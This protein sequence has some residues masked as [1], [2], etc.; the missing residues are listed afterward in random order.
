MTKFIEIDDSQKEFFWNNINSNRRESWEKLAEGLGISRPTMFNYKLGKTKIQQDIFLKLCKIGRIDSS[1]IKFNVTFKS[2]EIKK[3]ELDGI[4]AEF[5]GIIYG[6]GHLGNIKYEV[7]ITGNAITDK[8]YMESHVAPLF[9]DLF[10]LKPDIREQKEF[11]AIRCRVYSKELQMFLKSN[12]NTPSG[13]KTEKL[14]IPNKIKSN[15]KLLVSFIRGLF[16][17]DGSIYT[18]HGNDMMLEISVKGKVFRND[19]F[20]ALKYLGFSPYKGRKNVVI[21]RQSEIVRFFKLIKPKNDNHLV[22]Y[23]ELSMRR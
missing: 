6:D 9:G 12:F 20:L 1:K 2:K 11:T 8:K 4:L 16:D 19:I 5:L 23:S 21:Y 17:T 3:P 7:N 22:R 14:T 15:K 13:K 18:H 10:G